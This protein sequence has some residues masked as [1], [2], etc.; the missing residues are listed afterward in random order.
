MTAANTSHSTGL[1]AVSNGDPEQ[2]F[3]PLGK[4]GEG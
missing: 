3:T 4:L 2:L 1:I